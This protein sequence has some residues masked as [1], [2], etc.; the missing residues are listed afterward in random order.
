[1][2]LPKQRQMSEEDMAEKIVAWLDENGWD[3]YQE[4]QVWAQGPVADLVAVCRP[5]YWIIECKTNFGFKVLDQA[6][7]W[8]PYAHRVSVAVR[9]KRG[10]LLGIEEQTLRH[11]GI[12]LLTYRSTGVQES[13]RAELHRN[14]VT[15]ELQE[16][17]TPR[18]KTYARAGNPHGHRLTP[19]R[20]TCDRLVRF[21]GQNPGCTLKE[22]IDA[23]PHHY[24]SDLSARTA[25]PNLLRRGIIEGIRIDKQGG[26]LRLYVESG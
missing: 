7:R 14:V 16:T 19:F 22:A 21:V 25:L 1:M 8:T 26:R 4:V 13:V 23:I 3:V 12:G 15:K 17:L 2:G 20:L 10:G 11:F 5:V 9:W 24:S 18:H 6:L